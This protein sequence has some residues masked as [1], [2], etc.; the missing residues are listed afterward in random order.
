MTVSQLTAKC[1]ADSE[2]VT[3]RQRLHDLRSEILDEVA[4][5][6]RFG[7]EEEARTAARLCLWGISEWGI[8]T[9]Q[10]IE[11]DKLGKTD[12]RRAERDARIEAL[13]GPQ[14]E[15]ETRQERLKG[16]IPDIV[17]LN[18]GYGLRSAVLTDLDAFI[19]AMLRVG[20][21]N[22]RIAEHVISAHVGDLLEWIRLNVWQPAVK[23][24][25]DPPLLEESDWESFCGWARQIAREIFAASCQLQDGT[26]L[27]LK[28]GVDAPAT[29]T[30]EAGEV[31]SVRNLDTKRINDW[32]D[33]KG[34]TN[35]S[36][37]KEMN[38]RPR[39]VS[40]IRNNGRFH[41]WQ[42]VEKL[43]VLMGLQG[44]SDL[45]MPLG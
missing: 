38:V 27:S 34:Y 10:Q 15:P 39:V 26:D 31:N 44:A 42:A 5:F 9:P 4:H 7:A 16:R 36:L 22:L 25:G 28:A 17:V 23:G 1:E 33:E 32:M 8:P 30:V 45:L 13:T 2:Y 11:A 41:G 43:A 24:F 21:P 18:A 37:A 35:E 12:W 14:D 3:S 19:S 40:S 29:A 20:Y 6:S